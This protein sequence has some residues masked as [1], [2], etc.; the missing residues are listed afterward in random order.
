MNEIKRRAGAVAELGGR[1]YRCT[2]STPGVARDGMAI[3]T[4]SWDTS[5]FEKNPILLW[6]H[7]RDSVDAVLGRA[8][9]RKTPLSL[10]ADIEFLEPGV[11]EFADRVARLWEAGILR[12]VSVGASIRAAEPQ[13]DHLRV[14]DAE[15]L[16]ISCVPVGGDAL[17]LARGLDFDFLDSET[18][19]AVFD[20]TKPTPQQRG[21]R[22]RD[23][24]RA[25]QL[26]RR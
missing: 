20:L 19:A 15:L 8:T 26:A 14:T 3:P 9:V 10:E 2:A 24:L 6:A 16:E 22:H 25:L 5:N 18:V 12:A 17:A 21:G 1:R 4:E 13:A 23:R 11:S 7:Q